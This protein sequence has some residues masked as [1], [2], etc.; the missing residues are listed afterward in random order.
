MPNPYKNLCRMLHVIAN[1]GES[2]REIREGITHN[3]IET[4]DLLIIVDAFDD[5]FS[6]VEQ[7]VDRDGL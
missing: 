5:L 4:N 1:S 3:L 7:E 2:S 6:D